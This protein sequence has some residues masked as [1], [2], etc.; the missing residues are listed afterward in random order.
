MTTCTRC[1]RPLKRPTE[2]GMGPVCAK[3]SKAQ[4]VPAHDRDL[5]GFEVE[6]GIAAARYRVQV[7]IEASAAEAYIA[8]AHQFRAARERLLYYR[9]VQNK[10][11]RLRL[12]NGIVVEI[13]RYGCGLCF[14]CGHSFNQILLGA[15]GC[16]NCYG[17]GLE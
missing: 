5:F 9:P 15:R 3:A 2:T 12:P 10:G 8:V 1:H 4:P 6:K 11:D 14:L 7:Q 13:D 16:P 17:E